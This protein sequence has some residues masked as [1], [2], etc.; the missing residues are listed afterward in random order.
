MILHSIP[1]V[2]VNKPFRQ[3]L[4]DPDQS[5]W[6]DMFHLRI[7]SCNEKLLRRMQFRNIGSNQRVRHDE[8]N[9]Q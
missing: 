6:L 5:I 3:Y 2:L 7:I 8:E 9:S 4:C 1:T